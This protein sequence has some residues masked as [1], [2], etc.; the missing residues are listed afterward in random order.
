MLKNNKMMTCK[1][2]IK[3][4][5]KICQDKFMILKIVKIYNLVHKAVRLINHNKNSLILNQ[6]VRSNILYQIDQ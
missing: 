6:V 5:I 4:M 3:M 1:K 2:K